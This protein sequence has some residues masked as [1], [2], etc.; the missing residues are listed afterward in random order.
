QAHGDDVCKQFADVASGSVGAV[1]ERC[2]VAARRV[3]GV[4]PPAVFAEQLAQRLV[5]WRARRCSGGRGAGGCTCG[6]AADGVLAGGPSRRGAARAASAG[7]L[8]LPGGA[9]G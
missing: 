4:L 5:M 9:G 7:W 1:D 8:S 2:D 6:S 3:I